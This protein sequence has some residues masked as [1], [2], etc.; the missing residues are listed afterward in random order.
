MQLQ[1]E[2]PAP[3]VDCL[4]TVARFSGACQ[5][6]RTA[7]WDTVERVSLSNSSR[8]L[9]KIAAI[10]VIPESHSPRPR[11]A[12]HQSSRNGVRH[13]HEHDGDSRRSFFYGLSRVRCHGNKNGFE[14]FSPTSSAAGLGQPRETAA[15]MTVLNENVLSLNIAPRSRRPCRNAWGRGASAAAETAARYPTRKIFF[16]CCASTGTLRASRGAQRGIQK[17]CLIMNFS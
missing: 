5:C 17:I 12:F 6:H 13:A 7:R 9:V 3:A 1:T 14:G 2:F 4:A 10:F 16:G 8:L 15:L 11:Q